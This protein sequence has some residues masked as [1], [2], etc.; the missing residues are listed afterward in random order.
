MAT[1]RLVYNGTA[2]L[3]ESAITGRQVQWLPGRP[4]D[5]DA[6]IAGALLAYGGFSYSSNAGNDPGMSPLLGLLNQATGK[7]KKAALPAL[8]SSIVATLGFAGDSFS[9]NNWRNFTPTAAT[10][11]S[12]VVTVTQAS[13]AIPPGGIVS[14]T[15]MLNMAANVGNT[16]ATV[17]DSSHFSYPAPGCPDGDMMTGAPNPVRITDYSV[18]SDCGFGVWL[19]RLSGGAV[20]VVA[21]AGASGHTGRNSILYWD[22]RITPASPDFT[23]IAHTY[24]DL[25]QIAVGTAGYS[26]SS[27]VADAQAYI[28][29]AQGMPVPTIPMLL[30]ALPIVS[31][32]TADAPAAHQA[33]IYYNAI[34]KQIVQASGG[35]FIDGFQ[36]AVGSDG[37]GIASLFQAD[38]THY[39]SELM[40][41]IVVRL[42]TQLDFARYMVPRTFCTSAFDN[43]G[44]TGT[45]S[46]NAIRTLPNVQSPTGTLGGVTSAAVPSGRTGTAGVAT[47]Y[48]CAASAG[49]GG[50]PTANAWVNTAANGAS[51]QWQRLNAVQSGDQMRSSYTLPNPGDFPPGSYF[52]LSLI[53]WLL[54]DYNG[55]NPGNPAAQNVL[56]FTVRVISTV[57][58]VAYNLYS[59]TSTA[60]TVQSDLKAIAETMDKMRIPAGTTHNSTR[61][62]LLAQF[63]GTGSAEMGLAEPSMRSTINL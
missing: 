63:S 16:A 25:A 26:V 51:V 30:S 5:V 62:D 45:S 3:F 58:N 34:V 59:A 9:D 40:R 37:K 31:G 56:T 14:V 55:S 43:T 61:V 46:T 49:G 18:Q 33:V 8:I 44:A 12:G 6:S 42:L 36:D 41:R 11:A 21:N 50:T 23:F 19:N 20:Q 22:S 57:D 4:Q 10:C 52:Y 1:V 7:F 38:K 32:A 24:N 29:K 48:T 35:I 28:A 60:T 39:G 47:N 13:H 27:M 17:I 15:G 53:A 2:P 54:T